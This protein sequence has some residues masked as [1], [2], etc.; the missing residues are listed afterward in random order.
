M[1]TAI[2]AAR[3]APSLMERLRTPRARRVTFLIRRDSHSRTAACHSP[4]GSAARGSVSSRTTAV[5]AAS[6][7]AP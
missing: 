2:L 1:S 5:A 3:P 7:T 6:Q 4:S